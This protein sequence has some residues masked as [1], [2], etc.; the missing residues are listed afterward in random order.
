MLSFASALLILA[1]LS[2]DAAF[3]K[4]VAKFTDPDAL[5]LT[6]TARK[7]TGDRAEW[8]VKLLRPNMLL[9]E[10]ES[11][12][13]V[14]D[15]TDI[16]EM[17]KPAKAYKQWPQTAE[18][19]AE[20]TSRADLLPAKMFFDK[21]KEW[22]KKT[23]PTAPRS[24]AG[25]ALTGTK[26]TLGQTAAATFYVAPDG[27]IGILQHETTL[28]GSTETLLID[29]FELTSG[30]VEAALFA[31]A[32]PA[33]AKP[34]AEPAAPL[35]EAAK[36]ELAQGYIPYRTLT[37]DDFKIK[38]DGLSTTEYYIAAY[39]RYDYKSKSVKVGN[40]YQQLVTEFE[41]R[42][43]LDANN[44]WR[45]PKFAAE[46]TQL[47]QHEQGH[48]DLHEVKARAIR[49]A[50]PKLVGKGSSPE[51]AR[52]DLKA[53]ITELVDTESAKNKELVTLYDKDT[54]HGQNKAEQ[55]RWYV[56]IQN[57]LKNRDK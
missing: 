14:A 21:N 33:D 26:V 23:Q 3:D 16:T 38:N 57:L 29:K 30:P 56:R 17:R 28:A 18:S 34:E 2:L 19:L 52:A 40:Q 41:V 1:P 25:V 47:L 48:L 11:M 54:Q 53:K 5:T 9:A 45:G 55:E 22:V 6:Y 10:S 44:T 32:L 7:L 24:R 4:A 35:S 15:G 51:T 13:V 8:R 37:W 42:S 46:P 49:A 31:K 12:L 50:F 43:G 20:L 39:L 36:A 27:T